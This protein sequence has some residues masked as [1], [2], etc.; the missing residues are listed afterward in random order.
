MEILN[1]LNINYYK[2]SRIVI[3][4]RKELLKC[5]DD[6]I[7]DENLPVA[8]INKIVKL[9]YRESLN[10]KRHDVIENLDLHCLIG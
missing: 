2:K 8:T 6:L 3:E 10:L 1:F 9:V 4:Q 5:V 7:M